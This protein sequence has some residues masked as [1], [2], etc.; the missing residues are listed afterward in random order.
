MKVFTLHF[1]PVHSPRRIKPNYAQIRT[2]PPKIEH[3]IF[4][5]FCFFPK[6][7]LQNKKGHL[8]LLL[9]L[10]NSHKESKMLLANVAEIIQK[11][12]YS[13]IQSQIKDQNQAG[14]TLTEQ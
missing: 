4:D 3:S 11:E 8:F 1:N 2:Q 5:S 12:F 6:T 7:A 14:A 9:E 13:P 10:K